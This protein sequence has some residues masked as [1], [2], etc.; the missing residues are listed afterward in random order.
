[1]RFRPEKLAQAPVLRIDSS[2]QFA[3]IE[4][5]SDRVIRLARSRL[6]RWFLA[7]HHLRQ[8]I[9]IGD[10]AAIDRLIKSEEAGLVSQE[11]TDRNAVLALLSE[12]G[13]IHAH[14]LFVIEPTPRV[15][16]GKCHGGEALGGRVRAPSCPTLPRLAGL[17]CADP[18]PQVHDLLRR[19]GTRTRAA[20]FPSASKFSAK[21]LALHFEAP[22]TSL[23]RSLDLV[24]G[25]T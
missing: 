10:D 8:A 23:Q 2:Q 18:A 4:A 12:L 16:N 14:A 6:P 1:M 3:F 19:G 22:R 11:L 15:G 21:T 7:S 25:R 17:L 24:C 9:E 13:P 20:Q 5:K